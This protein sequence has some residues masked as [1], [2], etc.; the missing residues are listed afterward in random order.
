MYDEKNYESYS[1][2]VVQIGCSNDQ[3]NKMYQYAKNQK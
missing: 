3:I 2:K 1:F